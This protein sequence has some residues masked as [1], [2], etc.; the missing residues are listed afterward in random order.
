MQ[1]YDR[2]RV[3]IPIIGDDTE[4]GAAPAPPPKAS[5][6][7]G[8]GYGR[9]KMVVAALGGAAVLAVAGLR[10]NNM[11]ALGGPTG[12]EK[13]LAS[14]VRFRDAASRTL[15]IQTPR[16]FSL[17]GRVTRGGDREWVPFAISR[18]RSGR[19]AR[20]R[21]RRAPRSPREMA[22][23]HLVTAAISPPAD[24]RHPEPFPNRTPTSR[25]SPPPGSR[26]S[27]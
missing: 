3:L 9:A 17:V 14:Q 10:G 11:A 25:R 20:S 5:R 24:L 21:E 8:D 27:R 22:P 19:Y 18:A 23:K 1:S 16:W 26:A 2:S 6:Q 4:Y 12:I 15:S 7:Q 13:V